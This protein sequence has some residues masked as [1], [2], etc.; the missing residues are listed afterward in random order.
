MRFFFVGLIFYLQFCSC[1]QNAKGRVEK[2]I[3]LDRRDTIQKMP[4]HQ[5]QPMSEIN[6]ESRKLMIPNLQGKWKF[7]RRI[8]EGYVMTD[9]DSLQTIVI[10]GNNIQNFIENKCILNSEVIQ[11]GPNILLGTTKLI[12]KN[13]TII[14]FIL[15][16]DKTLILYEHESDDSPLLE[17]K[18]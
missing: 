1:T 7:V 8:V 15:D 13:G 6:S 4:P 14:N 3:N 18:R 9:M 5:T 11:A 2:P 12:L 16:K 10:K 17:Y